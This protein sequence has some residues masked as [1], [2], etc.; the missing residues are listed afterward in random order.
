MASATAE[1]AEK[2]NYALAVDIG[3]T[4]TDAVLRRADG[5]VWVDKVLTTHHDLLQ[6]FAQGVDSV[7][8]KAGIGPADVD[9]VVV[10]ATTVVTN[11]LIE[12]KGEKTALLTTEGFRDVLYIRDEYRYDMYDPQIEFPPPLVPHELTYGIPERTRADGTVTRAVEPDAVRAVAA[13]LREQGVVSVA[14][15]FLNAYRNPQNE[16]AAAAVLREELPGLYLSLSSEVSPQIREYPRTSTTVINAYT[17][18]IAGPYLTRM[19]AM[20]RERGFVNAPMVMLSNGGVIG[21]GIAARFPVR[22]IESGPAA[23]ALA[24]GYYA[25]ELGLDRLL[26][27]DMGGTTAKAC[28]IEHGAPLI[29]GYFEVD[30]KYRFKAGSGY[31]MT[32]PSI[33]MIEIGAGGGSIASCDA[34]KL[35]K[36]G[37]QSAGSMPGPVCYGKGGDDIC[38]TDAD[39]ALG[40]LDADHFLGG[41]MKLDVE[42]MRA[43]LAALADDLGV[44]PAD[45]AAGIYRIVGETMASAA[46]AHAVDRGVDYR[47][48]P[49]LAFGGAGPLHACYVAELLGSSTVIVP[50]NASVLSAFGMLVTPVRYDLVRGALGKLDAI[51]WQAAGAMFEEMVTAGRQ[52]LLDA[53]VGAD[54]VRLSFGGDLR[55][56]GQ[57]HEV[58]VTFDGDPREKWDLAGMRESFERTYEAHYGMRL[59]DNEVE[60]VNWRVSCVGPS[61]LR[62]AA[63][64]LADTPGAPRL[65]RSVHLGTGAR[66]DVRYAVYER[67]VLAAGQEIAGPAI[68]EERETTTVI[69]PGWTARIDATGCIIARRTAAQERTAALA[70]P[71]VVPVG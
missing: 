54:D 64:R 17:A 57:A 35:L 9:D 48:I 24:A 13:K 39:L 7:L 32:V 63:P 56:Y 60:V 38:V 5:Q 21:G 22:M 59:P 40:L 18:P 47:G 3:G 26:A 36:V 52:A 20:L 29:T 2:K 68:V 65:H 16:R 44:T 58:A 70:A 19:T 42:R 43:R 53:G 6:A 25:D 50:P 14:I 66:R 4:F 45:A 67:S 55:Y 71:S 46:R 51:D 33:D 62:G 41:E 12:R 8:R 31:P 28:L 69:L 37:P 27:F 11:A 61:I 10:H 34:L 23:G 15:A 30:R 1:R 49:L